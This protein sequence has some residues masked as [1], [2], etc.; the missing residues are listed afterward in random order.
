MLSR[1]I[2]YNPSKD[3]NSPAILFLLFF[4]WLIAATIGLAGEVAGAQAGAGDELV[5]VHGYTLHAAIVWGA[6]LVYGLWQGA[7]L[8]VPDAGHARHDQSAVSRPAA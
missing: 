7:R 2:T 3:V 1:S 4:T 8:P 6:W 5:Q